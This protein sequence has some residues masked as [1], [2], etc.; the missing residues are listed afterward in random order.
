MISLSRYFLTYTFMPEYEDELGIDPVERELDSEF[1]RN[2]F[3]QE[4]EN[5]KAKEAR[6]ETERYG[7]VSF[8][9]A[10]S[11]ELGVPQEL[12]EDVKKR[13]IDNL[14]S[15]KEAGDAWGIAFQSRYMQEMDNADF[16]D[17]LFFS[18]TES[19][20]IENELLKRQKV[21]VEDP[22]KWKEFFAM[23]DHV[24]EVAPALF[25][26]MEI[27]ESVAEG[28]AIALEA[29]EGKEADIA[30]FIHVA[31]CAENCKSGILADA[32]FD[33]KALHV[34]VD[35]A[36]AYARSMRSQ[37]NIWTYSFVMSQT[38][39]LWNAIEHPKESA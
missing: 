21:A 16:E 9:A 17:E 18:E 36:I 12:D 10:R 24:K 20:L 29:L 30:D 6:G 33:R 38:K 35:E 3:D 2:G 7:R 25:E 28:L 39:K 19:E 11:A 15:K 26:K 4:V 1:L 14:K 22:E 37:R 23:A 13:I 31:Y 5:A 27:D 32:G 34:K 8:V